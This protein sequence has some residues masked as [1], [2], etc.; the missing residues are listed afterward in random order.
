MSTAIRTAKVGLFGTAGWP[1]RACAA[2]PGDDG[3]AGG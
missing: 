3:P 2:A 1:G